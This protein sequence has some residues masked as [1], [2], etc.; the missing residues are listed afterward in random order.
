MAAGRRSWRTCAHHCC[1]WWC[2]RRR[3]CRTAPRTPTAAQLQRR[4]KACSHRLRCA[5]IWWTR[6]PAGKARLRHW[7]ASRAEKKA[8]KTK[9][10]TF[11]SPFRLH[12]VQ[13]SQHLDHWRKIPTYDGGSPLESVTIYN[14]GVFG[15]AAEELG[16]R[17]VNDI[18]LYL[19]Y[20][21]SFGGGIWWWIWLVQVE[22][23][24][25]VQRKPFI[26]RQER[27]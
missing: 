22:G 12:A 15:G 1:T 20:I 11:G 14:R 27:T 18:A 6:W 2:D 7:G 23:P 16:R 26:V 21:G 9:L 17:Q 25:R 8:P 4:C 3:A 5:W 10:N 13:L 24:E 19:I